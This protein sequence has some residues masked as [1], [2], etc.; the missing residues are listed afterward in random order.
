MTILLMTTAAIRS[1]TVRDDS[2]DDIGATA[3]YD[4]DGHAVTANTKHT[5]DHAGDCDHKHGND[6]TGG[7]YD[8]NGYAGDSHV[9]HTGHASQSELDNNLSI[10]QHQT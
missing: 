5:H 8:H 1:V 3:N 10:I 7:L 4:K 2:A 6:V 9:V